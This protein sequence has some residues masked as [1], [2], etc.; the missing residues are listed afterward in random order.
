MSTDRYL[1]VRDEF[2][3]LAGQQA[4][5]LVPDAAGT[6]AFHQIV[7]ACTITFTYA[8]CLSEDDL[9]IMMDLGEMTAG[10][11]GW[12]TLMQCNTLAFGKHSPVL[13]LSDAGHLTLQKVFPLASGSGHELHAVV[14][15]LAGWAGRWHAG[16]WL[17]ADREHPGPT[18]MSAAMAG[19]LA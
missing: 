4:P 13:G 10:E 16:D 2:C 7:G 15:D 6:M 5:T 14:R 8:P 1:A 11:A 12:R 18:P 17:P 9:F 3:E 19:G